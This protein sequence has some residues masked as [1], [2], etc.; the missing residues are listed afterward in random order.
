MALEN[1]FEFDRV[2]HTPDVFEL[3]DEPPLLPDAARSTLAICRHIATT[4]LLILGFLPLYLLVKLV[5]V[6]FQMW[7]MTQVK[8][9]R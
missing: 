4:T 9:R 2:R 7:R 1:H 3:F 8:L 6:T 5:A